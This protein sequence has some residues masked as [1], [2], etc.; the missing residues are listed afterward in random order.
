[1]FNTSKLRMLNKL[2]LYSLDKIYL[3]NIILIPVSFLY[4]IINLIKKNFYKNTTGN[5]T[6][7][8]VVGNLTVGGTGKTS[9]V[10]WLANYLSKLNYK[11]GIISGGYKT[12][13]P[14]KLERV[15]DKSYAFEVGDEALLI[16]KKTKCI[17]AK[18][19]NRKIAYEDLNINCNHKLDIII[20]DDGLH[21]YNLNRDLDIV[22]LKEEKPFGNK[23][24]VPAGP[25][26]EIF[27]NLN[28]FDNIIY[29]KN[30]N[31]SLRGF[32]YNNST[33]VSAYPDEKSYKITDFKNK[34]V[35][36]VTSV[37]NPDL[38]INVLKKYN[39]DVISHIY[40]DHYHFMPENFIFNDELDIFMT[41]KDYV[42]VDSFRIVRAY[43]FPTDIVVDNDIKIMLNDKI[44]KLLEV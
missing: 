23:L 33:L 37:A 38:L 36:L 34:S 44:S 18:C 22:I 24:P 12:L 15:N 41:E 11:V 21:H 13:N 16:Y 26:R 7:V 32:Y 5:S 19:K 39:I 9:L 20:S 17:V 1:M 4:V 31:S 3:L 28:N 29:N 40:P 2:Y 35:H 27:F 43:Y 25:L 6:P 10:I 14:N 42:K 8:I 30:I